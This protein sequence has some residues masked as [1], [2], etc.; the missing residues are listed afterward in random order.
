MI[1][2]RPL[3]INDAEQ[4]IEIVQQ[5]PELFNGYSDEQYKNQI[6]TMIPEIL[7][8]P[9]W[10]NLGFFVD[11]Q[12]YGAGLMKEFSSSPAWCWAHWVVR[13]GAAGYIASEEGLKVLRDLDQDLFDEMEINR[14]L[15]RIFL[16]Y[17]ADQLDKPQTRS[18]G[19][20]ERVMKLINRQGDTRISKYEFFTECLVEPDTMP[21]Y[22]YQQAMLLNRTWPIRVG[23]CVGNLKKDY[24][25][26]NG[27]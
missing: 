18:I 21:K 1:T 14:K 2:H 25:N 26:F 19:T 23:I 7:S 17:R 24:S 5:R 15:S 8:N 11:G 20:F 13:R 12:L 6:P 4:L 22:E 10:F 3:T 16:A 27:S 9:L